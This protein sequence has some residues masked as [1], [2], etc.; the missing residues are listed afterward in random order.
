MTPGGWRAR[1]RI[2]VFC[3]RTHRSVPW[4]GGLAAYCNEPSTFDLIRRAADAGAIA[5]LSGVRRVAA[6]VLRL[7]A[8]IPSRLLLVQD[9]CAK[10]DRKYT[11]WFTTYCTIHLMKYRYTEIINT[12]HTRSKILRGVIVSAFDSGSSERD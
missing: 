6:P 5:E 11:V 12:L 2:Y 7:E 10:R 4:A 3:R 1:Q 9:D 8:M